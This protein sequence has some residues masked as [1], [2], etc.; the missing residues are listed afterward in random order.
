MTDEPEI[1]LLRRAVNDETRHHHLDR[2]AA[3]TA[4]SDAH[5]TRPHHARTALAVAATVIVVAGGTTV[6]VQTLGNGDTTSVLAGPSACSESISPGV[7]PTWARAGFSP[8]DT[9][10]PHVLSANGTIVAILFG[11]LR[12]HQTAGSFNKILWVAKDGQGEMDITAQ[13]EGSD[14]GVTRTVDLGPSTVDLP[15]AGCWQM[16]LT[17]PGHQD[18]IAIRYE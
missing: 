8:A 14:T 12:A 17:W 16:A 4:W 2:H 9:P 3:R 10:I 6:A 15:A 18:T 7:L 11:D 13:L 1:G 5:A